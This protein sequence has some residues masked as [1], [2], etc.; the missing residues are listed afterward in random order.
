VDLARRALG[1]DR[2]GHLGTL[3]PFAKGLLVLVVGRATRL[4]PFAAE[5]PKSYEG[6]IRLGVATD[7][8]DLTGQ[9]VTTAPWTGITP[10][11]LAEVIG[12]FRGG[13]EQTPPAYSAVKVA[14]E[15]ANPPAP[16]GGA[17]GP[18]AAAPPRRGED[19]ALEPRAVEIRELEIVEAAVPDLRFRA[20]VS[21]GTYLRSLARDIGAALGCG[22]HLAAL[23][24]T[25]VGPLTLEDA[26]PPPAITAEALRDASV[27]V[28]H[29][30]RRDVDRKERDALLH[31][32]P[33]TV[34]PIAD[35]RYP[36]AVFSGDELIAVAEQSGELLKPRVVLAG[37]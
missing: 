27:L 11:Q 20:T 19:V 33:V 7:T 5:W 22:A 26:V 37:D 14:G 16:R 28:A 17:V 30:P 15:G 4:A 2:I 3:D 8:D 10:G 36:I 34:E 12:R 29:L 32:R 18:P 1:E 31:G 21:A 13:Y 6:V 24:R 25:A 35:S 9:V 23:R